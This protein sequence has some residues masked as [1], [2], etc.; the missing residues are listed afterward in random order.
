M[1]FVRL[2]ACSLTALA[3]FAAPDSALAH[4]TACFAAASRETIT[5]HGPQ[6]QAMS[7]QL[8]RTVSTQAGVAH[9]TTY[10]LMRQSLLI[11]RIQRSVESHS[12]ITCAVD[13]D[14]I[15]RDFEVLRTTWKAFAQ[16]DATLE[17]A[18]LESKP[19]Q[20]QLADIDTAMQPV[21]EA[22]AA[23]AVVEAD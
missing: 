10:L 15:R 8:V 23:L 17:I 19:A 18:R 22:V 4:D 16:G 11:E 7:D 5:L 9:A 21:A 20:D 6:L 13:L 14:R 1:P 2:G 12:E 3:L